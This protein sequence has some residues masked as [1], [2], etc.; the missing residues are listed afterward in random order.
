MKAVIPPSLK[1]EA[2]PDSG[3]KQDSSNRTSRGSSKEPENKLGKDHKSQDRADLDNKKEH[4]TASNFGKSRNS[5]NESKSHGESHHGR[6]QQL[7]EDQYL[8]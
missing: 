5:E 3:E 6:K 7:D 2:E 4:R 8:E 1:E